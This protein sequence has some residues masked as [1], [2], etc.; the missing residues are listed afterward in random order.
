ML[1]RILV[2]GP[3]WSVNILDLTSAD[4]EYNVT[5]TAYQISLNL[6]KNHY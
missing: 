1:C 4:Y 2:H 6:I 5:K 3:D